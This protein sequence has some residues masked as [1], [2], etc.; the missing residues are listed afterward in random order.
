MVH[1]WNLYLKELNCT[2]TVPLFLRVWSRH[3]TP[4]QPPAS[5]SCSKVGPPILQG[6]ASLSCQSQINT[7][8]LAAGL[9]LGIGHRLG[10]QPSIGC[11]KQPVGGVCDVVHVGPR[12]AYQKGY[13]AGPVQEV[14]LELVHITTHS[15]VFW[16]NDG[17]IIPVWSSLF[18]QIHHQV[19]SRPIAQ[20]SATCGQIT[21]HPQ[22]RS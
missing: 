16:M 20:L 11:A 4:R 3:S 14:L 18:S 22:W 5:S 1:L 10:C 19:P 6:A 12:E 21:W 7:C 8:A 2:L 13:R 15:A 17:S 9:A